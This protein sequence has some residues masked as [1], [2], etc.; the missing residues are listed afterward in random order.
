M[1]PEAVLKRFIKILFLFQKV[2]LILWSVWYDL[3]RFRFGAMHPVLRWMQTSALKGILSYIRMSFLT[4]KGVKP[5]VL[6]MLQ[7]CLPR[8]GLHF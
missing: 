6:L 8:I 1:L 3:F 2:I 7:I 5:C 4:R